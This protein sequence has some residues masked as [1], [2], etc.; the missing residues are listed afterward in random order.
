[1]LMLSKYPPAVVAFAGSAILLVGLIGALVWLERPS[2]NSLEIYCAAAMVPSIDAIAAEY[3]AFYGQGVVIHP[4]PSRGVLQ[5]MAEAKRGDLFLPA[6]ESYVEEAVRKNLVADVTNVAKMHAVVIVRPGH[7]KQVKTWND[8][9]APGN[10][11]A[12][13]NPEAAAIGMLT[14]Q[15]L[16][17][18]GLWSQIEAIKPAYLGDV[19]EVGNSVANLEASD[20]G[21]TWD[22]LAQ[23]LAKR[24][25][26]LQVVRLPEFADVTARVQIAVAHSTKQR[27][28]AL[29]FIRFLRAKNRGAVILKNAGF[30]DVEKGAALN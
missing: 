20:M 30:A 3:K 11:L 18:R 25:P 26:R 27:E 17:K 13:A 6:D 1:M 4:G 21:V 14:R 24:Y 10:K 22:V 16:K 7:G 19:A 2:D 9:V 29:R 8:L 23:G 12:L 5:Q 28:A 15:A